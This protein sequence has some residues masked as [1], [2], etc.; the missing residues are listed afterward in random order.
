M[1][2]LAMLLLYAIVLSAD[3][4]TLMYEIISNVLDN[5]ETPKNKII[6]SDDENLLKNLGKHYKTSQTCQ[7]STFIILQKSTLEAA[8]KSKDIFVLN[9]DLLSTMPESLGAFFFQKGRANI[10]LLKP[11]LK[12]HH[13]KPSSELLPYLEDK[14]W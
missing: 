8:C 11:K 14:I 3:S 2:L 9:Y 10:V 7:E 1:K 5:L 6:Y 4:K 13:I 12:Q